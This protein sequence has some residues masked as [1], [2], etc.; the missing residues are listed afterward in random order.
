MM[1]VSLI[2]KVHAAK[3][4][5]AEIDNI[6]FWPDLLRT[7]LCR[8]S[9]CQFVSCT[10]SLATF[11]IKPQ[12]ELP[13]ELLERGIV[14]MPALHLKACEKVSRMLT[15]LGYIQQTIERSP[16][17]GKRECRVPMDWTVAS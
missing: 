4:T 13:P 12:F 16:I 3:L 8:Y 14:G 6:T 2:W 7:S 17:L 11:L 5:T 1:N 15:E 9:C 10:K